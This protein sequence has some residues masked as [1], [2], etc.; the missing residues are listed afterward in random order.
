M[1]HRT[2]RSTLFGAL[3]IA[4]LMLSVP[5][6][7]QVVVKVNDNVNFRFGMQM[8]FW[9]DELQDATTKGYAQNLFL[10]RAR[11]LVTGQVAPNVT[12]FFQTDN[13]NVGKAPKAL[14]SGFILQDAWAEVKFND[15]FMLDFGEFLVP[16]SRNE[17]TSTSSF[18]TLD[19][20]PTSVV[21]AG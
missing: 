12:F 7:A 13:P 16:T 6:R 1:A 15:Q 5:A 21:F 3:V 18:L 20:S 10:R 8:Q 14:Q 9:A 4:A 19:V 2:L 11:F 17:L